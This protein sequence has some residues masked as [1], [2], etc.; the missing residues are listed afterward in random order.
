MPDEFVEVD[1]EEF[2]GLLATGFRLAVERLHARLAEAG[3]DEIRP[4]HGF[5]FTRLSLGGATASELAEHLG[6]TKQAAGQMV[7]YLEERGYVTREPHP[8]DRRIKLITLAPR[9]RAC[10]GVAIT[11]KNEIAAHW[12]RLA[13]IEEFAVARDVFSA[14]LA[15]GDL[16]EQGGL[17]PTW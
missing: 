16:S 11:A 2:F 7:D 3:F 10:I 17:R 13:G 4:A 12:A 1:G 9:G 6:V 14:L 8:S 15:D 5:A